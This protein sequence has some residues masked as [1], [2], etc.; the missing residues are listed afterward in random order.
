VTHDEEDGP[1]RGRPDPDAAK[2]R[3]RGEPNTT[4]GHDVYMRQL[5]ARIRW[6]ERHDHWWIR[7]IRQHQATCSSCPRCDWEPGVAA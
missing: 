7:M 2:R 5:A 3:I 1:R 4:V 6:L